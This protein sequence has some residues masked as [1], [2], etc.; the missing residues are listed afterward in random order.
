MS[1]KA[2]YMNK[3]EVVEVAVPQVWLRKGIAQSEK[4]DMDGAGTHKVWEADEVSFFDAS[5]T[6]AYA[7]EHFD[8]LWAAHTQDGTATR[9]IALAAQQAG[10]DNANAI[11]DLAQSVSDGVDSSE[12][13]QGALADLAQTVSDLAAEVA[14]L[15]AAKE[16]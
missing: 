16:A 10:S 15:K 12:S 7:K 1:A 2:Q 5:V 8:E 13:A 14:A 3:P 6:E 4:P 11:A 9:D